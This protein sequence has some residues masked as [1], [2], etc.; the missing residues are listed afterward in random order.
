MSVYS[1]SAPTV[2]AATGAAY[3]GFY[4]GATRAIKI[5]KLQLY[6]TAATLSPVR[7]YRAATN[8]TTSST[9]ITPPSLALSTDAA[10]EAFHT[11]WSVAPTISTNVAIDSTWIPASIGAGYVMIFDF[12]QELEIAVSSAL[13][14][15][16]PSG[17]TGSALE[18]CIK[19]RV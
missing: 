8:G 9:A 2:A 19:Y 6:A 1:F 4:T 11:T 16:N 17:S 15:W 5:Q 14:I 3:A 10:G 7:I 18:C 12:G 13:L